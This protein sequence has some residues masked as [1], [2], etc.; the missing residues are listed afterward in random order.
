MRHLAIMIRV[1]ARTIA[2]VSAAT[3]GTL[4]IVGYVLVWRD[5]P[6]TPVQ[7]PPPAAVTSA[8]NPAEPHYGGETGEDTA[9]GPMY[10]PAPTATPDADMLATARRFAAAWARPNLTTTAWLD[11]VSSCATNDYVRELEDIDP[12]NV[13]AT[14]VT[15]D[16]IVVTSRVDEA[17]V[18]VPTDGGTLR[19]H[20]VHLVGK[21]WV[22][23]TE[24]NVAT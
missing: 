15:G 19:L 4:A 8:P 17:D 1:H 18:D 23:S 14:K 5:A 22:T 20:L 13:P 11:G 2:Y 21:W 9:D 6:V 3:V 12:A 7:A 24:W 10:E 16:P